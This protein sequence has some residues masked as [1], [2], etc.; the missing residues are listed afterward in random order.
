ME[1]KDLDRQR[2]MS[3]ASA[4]IESLTKQVA[5]KNEAIHIYRA[6]WENERQKYELKL[7]Q[8]NADVERL[9]EALAN[10]GDEATGQLRKALGFLEDMPRLPTVSSYYGIHRFHLIIPFT[11]SCVFLLQQRNRVW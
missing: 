11:L 8:R 7:Q 3:T 1:I 2:M 10:A 6:M 9:Q 5:K 4:Q